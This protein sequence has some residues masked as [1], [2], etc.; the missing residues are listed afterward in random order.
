[1]ISS[2]IF[3]KS[4]YWQV[5]HWWLS[6]GIFRLNTFSEFFSGDRAGLWGLQFLWRLVEHSAYG[7]YV[8]GT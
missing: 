3:D 8:F 7:F 6:V 1:M 4:R 2:I 5:S